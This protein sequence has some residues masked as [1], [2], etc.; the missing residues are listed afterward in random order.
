[1]RKIDPNMPWGCWL[2]IEK[3]DAGWRYVDDETGATW[4][5]VRAAFCTEQLGLRFSHGQP[6][7]ALLETV[8]AVLALAARRPV[9][10][11]ELVTDLFLGSTTFAG[12][13]RLFLVGVGLIKLD[14]DGRVIVGLTRVG[15]AALQMLIATRPHS[16]RQSPPT[17]A[18]IADLAELGMG[19]EGREDR[20]ARLETDAVAWDVAFLRRDQ[21]GRP[22]VILSVRG[23]GP[24]Q[25]M[26]TVWSLAFATGDERDRFYEWLCHR[27]DR[28]PDWAE[29][30]SEFGSQKLTHRLLGVMAAS[31]AG[32]EAAPPVATKVAGLIGR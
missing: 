4:S 19:P 20:L 7:A 9:D 21:A 15:R 11:R 30:A 28:W 8:H 5:S 29:L 24:M 27:L 13:L 31:L 1:M 22:T 12:F 16:A 32:E 25:N 3:V 26:Q 23:S 14:E 2:R 6:S 18:T 10:D 17:H